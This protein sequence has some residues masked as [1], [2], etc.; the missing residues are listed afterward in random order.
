MIL[1][2]WKF[3]KL[4]LF[5]IVFFIS[6]SKAHA[7]IEYDIKHR[8][9]I[10]FRIGINFAGAIFQDQDIL[11]NPYTSNKQDLIGINIGLGYEFV[12]FKFFSGALSL[13]ASALYTHKGVKLKRTQGYQVNGTDAD[14]DVYLQYI[15]FPIL[16]HYNIT[17]FRYVLLYFFAGPTL[18]FKITQNIDS[19]N[20]NFPVSARDAFNIFDVGIKAGVGVVFNNIPIEFFYEYGFLDF[21]KSDT[22]LPGKTH[23]SVIGISLGYKIGF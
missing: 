9:Y 14:A 7:V 19:N 15:S 20:A 3:Y 8:H 13:G 22:L 5:A 17:I 23:N 18:N 10:P 16:L 1:Y 4:L 2:F 12:F 6:Y 21:I 11:R